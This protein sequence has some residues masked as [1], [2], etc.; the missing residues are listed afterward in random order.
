M[1]E[2]DRRGREGK[3]ERKGSHVGTSGDEIPRGR[4]K[5]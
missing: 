5:R 2:S 1:T 4:K 3:R